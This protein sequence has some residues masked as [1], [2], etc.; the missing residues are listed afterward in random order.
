MVLNTVMIYSKRRLIN[1]LF[2]LGLGPGFSNTLN[3]QYLKVKS[4]TAKIRS[5]AAING[6]DF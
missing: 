3:A 1:I 2:L 4:K 6:N 5:V